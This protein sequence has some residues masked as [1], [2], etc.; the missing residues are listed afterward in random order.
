MA[1]QDCVFIFKGNW[2]NRIWISYDFEN[3]LHPVDR[4]EEICV[5]NCR[6][7]SSTSMCSWGQRQW[8]G[9]PPK[10]W[11]GRLPGQWPPQ[12]TPASS[13]TCLWGVRW[14][15]SVP[16]VPVCGPEEGTE[17]YWHPPWSSCAPCRPSGGWAGQRCAFRGSDPCHFDLE[18]NPIRRRATNFLT[19]SIRTN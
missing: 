7:P 10:W 15:P 5:F 13:W 12:P 2:N 18:G 19:F 8:A 16:S 11:E 4:C 1:I 3:S 17:R 14:G 9:W 6:S